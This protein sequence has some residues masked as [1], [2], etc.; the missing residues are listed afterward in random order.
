MDG[1]MMNYPLTL[2]HLL[3]RVNGLFGKVEVVS[4]LPDRSVHRYCY[5]E[6][7]RRAR[8]LAQALSAAG[9][10]RG[11]RVATLMWNHYRHLEAYFGI[12]ASG[13]V[14][15]TLNLRLH[16]GE[17]GYIAK[18]AGDKLV[19]VDDVLLPLLEQ[20]KDEAG[21]ERVIVVR[22]C[23]DEAGSRYED[24]EEFIGRVDGAF[25]YPAI[26]ENEA[27]A[28]CYTSGTTGKPK[29]VLYSHRALVL[30]TF[31]FALPDAFGVGQRDVLLA[32]A[33]MFHANSHGLPYTA[34]MLG[35]KLVL[36]GKYTDPESVLDLIHSEQVTVLTAV[37]TVWLGMLDALEKHP[38]RWKLA[39]GLRGLA[40][41]TAP[42]ESMLRRF[43]RLG[44]S[45]LHLWGMTETTPAAT[46]SRLKSYMDAL[47]EDER[48]RIR[49]RQG[50]ALPFVEIRVADNDKVLPCDGESVGELQVRGPWV[51]ASYFNN[52]DESRRWTKDG[53]FCT[54]DVCTID[55]EGFMRLVDR[56]KDM[57]KS[58]GEW[59]SSVDLESEL[60]NH[61]AIKEAGVVAVPHAKWDERPLA[62]IVTEPESQLTEHE[63]REFLLRKFSK[64][65][66]PDAFIFVT[67]L[68]HTSTGK[69]LK[70]RLRE[71]YKDFAWTTAA[72]K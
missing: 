70:S 8:Q 18:H 23:D 68:P 53:W 15:H 28:M 60:M 64:W 33:P 48:Y 32:L 57:I 36:P 38:G 31:A 62:V 44:V 39:P 51:A 3:E 55:E 14:V 9:V 43:D 54:G 61:P 42:P 49:S 26:G 72:G 4:R 1:L 58:G 52:P 20:F 41:G 24:Y 13:A 11:D 59:I 63:L 34:V 35:S 56:T 16:P 17:L 27:A 50:W 19:I 5:S 65:Q 47:P 30:H 37:P 25:Q 29:G 12:P 7:Y 2:L 69:L 6:F 40:G 46:V 22:H 66:L 71:Q 21:F 67:E 45:L 10:Q